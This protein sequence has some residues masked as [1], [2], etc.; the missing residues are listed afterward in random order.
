MFTPQAQLF[1]NL[2]KACGNRNWLMLIISAF[3]FPRLIKW[4]VP[5]Q[6]LKHFKTTAFLEIF[7][8]GKEGIQKKNL[9]WL[10]VECYDVTC[11]DRVDFRSP[12]KKLTF[13]GN[14]STKVMYK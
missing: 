5:L 7:E 11:T 1:R 6:T 12:F 13:V 9:A 8:L 3:N 10:L 14:N 2:V 4:A